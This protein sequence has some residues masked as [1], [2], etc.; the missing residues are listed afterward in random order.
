M[1]CYFKCTYFIIP[2]AGL[3]IQS[4]IYHARGCHSCDMLFFLICFVIWDCDHIFNKFCWNPLPQ[5]DVS[6]KWLAFVSVKHPGTP[7]ACSN[8]LEI[9]IQ[10]H[11]LRVPRICGYYHFKPWDQV[12]RDFPFSPSLQADT[13][14][15]QLF[16]LVCGLFLVHFYTENSISKPGFIQGFYFELSSNK[17]LA[18]FPLPCLGIKAIWLQPSKKTKHQLRLI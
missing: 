3:G 13:L 16:M 4:P 11:G 2:I 6:P 15:H 18:S 14:S 7:L 8:F 12:H 9:F 1:F 5:G 17:G 10:F